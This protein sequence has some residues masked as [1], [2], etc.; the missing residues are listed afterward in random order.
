MFFS[1]M[2]RMEDLSLITSFHS[3]KDRKSVLQIAEQ[4][5][6]IEVEPVWKEPE[7]E[8]KVG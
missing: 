2:Q 6:I 5:D 7:T 3:C 8:E 1:S 4:M